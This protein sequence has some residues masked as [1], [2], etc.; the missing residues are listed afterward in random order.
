MGIALLVQLALLPLGREAWLY[1]RRVLFV[2]VLE[3]LATI[4][5]VAPYFSARHGREQRRDRRP[6]RLPHIPLA[7]PGVMFWNVPNAGH[8]GGLSAAPD[9]YAERMVTLFEEAFGR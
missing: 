1:K 9:V 8:V 3:V 4:Y 6:A 5:I 2:V 7:S